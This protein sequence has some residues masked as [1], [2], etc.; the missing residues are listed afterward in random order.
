LSEPIKYFIDISG[1]DPGL[2]AV[3]NGLCQ[4]PNSGD[5]PHKYLLQRRWLRVPQGLNEIENRKSRLYVE[6]AG[7]RAR[8]QN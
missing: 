2:A 3:L 7:D 5:M 1:R 6:K 8:A 4:N